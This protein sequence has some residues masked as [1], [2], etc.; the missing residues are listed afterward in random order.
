MVK[1]NIPGAP[2]S[3]DEM[4]ELLG[5]GY[6]SAFYGSQF[7]AKYGWN[8]V[9]VLEIIGILIVWELLVSG[10][11]LWNPKFV[12]PPSD[13]FSAFKDLFTAKDFR[14]NPIPFFENSIWGDVRFSATSFFYGY[15]LGATTGIIIGVAIG[16]S[17]LLNI[18]IG[19]FVWTAYA[20]PRSALAPT[21]VLVFKLGLASKIAM[22]FLFVVFVVIINTMEG[23]RTVG[24]ELM[25]AG[26][27][28]GANRRELITKVVLPY[29]LPFVMVGLRIGVVRG[30]I[31]VILGEFVGSKAGLGLILRRAAFNFET[32][33]SLAVV[34]L[35]IIMANGSMLIMQGIK[36]LVVPWHQDEGRLY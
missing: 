33:E 22:V 28:F 31:G 12:P 24:P 20:I 13:V 8:L 14:G 25:R 21:L 15:V 7:W 26:Q 4:E 19:P 32:A 10:I 6:E 9:L 11:E 18:M 17:R 3:V 30:W 27:V 34:I 1:R 35:F 23:I 36:K 16:S 5:P 2:P 29:V